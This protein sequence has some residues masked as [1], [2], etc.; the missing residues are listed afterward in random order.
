MKKSK[1]LAALLV[2]TMVF[3]LLS[4]MGF[5]SAAAYEWWDLRGY[6][7]NTY[8]SAVADVNSPFAG[9]RD[10]IGTYDG[11][12]LSVRH[13]WGWYAETPNSTRQ[14]IDI[15]VP[16]HATADSPVLHMVNN[17]GWTSNSYPFNAPV[18]NA[19]TGIFTPGN[20]TSANALNRGYIVMTNGARTYGMPT[21]DVSDF[22]KSPATMAD[23]KAA[24][25]F[26]RANM[27]PDKA[28][29]VGNPEWVFVTGTSGGGAMSNILGAS[30]DSPDYFSTMYDIGAL[31][32]S[33]ISNTPYGSATLAQKTDGANWRDTLSD[34]YLG[35]AAWCPMDDFPMG[36]QAMAWFNAERR[37]EQTANQGTLPAE[38]V[39]TPALMNATNRLATEFVE[40]ANALGLKDENGNA[41]TAT[42]A[43]KDDP[44]EGGIA[45]GSFLDA[46]V[47]L[48]EKGLERA[49]NLWATGNNTDYDAAAFATVVD[50]IAPLYTNEGVRNNILI[51]GAPV[52]GPVDAITYPAN[53]TVKITNL[54]QYL[55][56]LNPSL[57]KGS[58]FPYSSPGAGPSSGVTPFEPAVWVEMADTSGMYGA[59][60]QP[61]NVLNREAWNSF[62]GPAAA[63]PR[64]GRANSDGQAWD[65]YLRTPAGQTHALQLKMA[66]SIPYLNAGNLSAIPYLNDSGFYGSDEA[67]P[68]KYWFVRY[69]MNDQQI[70]YAMLTTLY[71]SLMNNPAVDFDNCEVIPFNWNKPHTGGYENIFP[72]IDNAVAIEIE[73]GHRVAGVTTAAFVEKLNGNQNRLWIT[74][75]VLQAN[76][77]SI[78]YTMAFMISNNAAGIYIIDTDYGE[79]KVYVDTKGNDQIRACY[80]VE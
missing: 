27:G 57:A 73:A 12:P 15:Y 38:A 69:G 36:E 5:S 24:L 65:D 52:T 58:I 4:T 61:K 35:V 68:A 67:S 16:S 48:L 51:N 60:D 54:P 46:T 23:Y 42:Y 32:L 6:Q 9:W 31:G 49:I 47:R 33:W 29:K 80:L 30:G 64:A 56:G 72:F 74:V 40:Y 20:N 53:S 17:S 63:Y 10:L 2:L 37:W 75:T 14:R 19:S 3:S 21:G 43:V 79:Y 11:H 39:K 7:A 66:S 59:N 55:I 13:Y 44:D 41:L 34:S 70:S 28:I 77:N 1:L 76:G 22:A 25:R 26:L 62:V 8:S 71:Y 18:Y 78:N 50:S 45:G